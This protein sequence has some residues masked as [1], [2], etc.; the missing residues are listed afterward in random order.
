MNRKRF[1]QNFPTLSPSERN[2]VFWA[3]D[4]AKC[5]HRGQIRDSGERYFEHPRGVAKIL[6][7]HGYKSVSYLVLAIIHDCPEDTYVSISK[8]ERL[9]GTMITREVLTLSKTYGIEDPV[10]GFVRR[11]RRR[12]S[13]TYYGDIGRSSKR[14]ILVKIADRIYNSRDLINP[15]KGSRWTPKKRLAKVAETRKWILPL[16]E[17]YEPR[18]AKELRR[19]CDLIEKSAK[20]ARASAP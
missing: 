10:T 19:L 4:I 6:F 15:P 2:R 11:S 12:T 1:F 8:I 3:Y 16:A 13:K 18:F 5:R 17:K 9:F 7:D 20:K 14:A